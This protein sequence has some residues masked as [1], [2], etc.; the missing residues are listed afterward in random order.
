VSDLGQK[1]IASVR[2]LASERPGY[3]Y[4]R[5]NPIKNTAGSCVYVADGQPS[6]IVGHA[7]WELKLIGPEFEDHFQNSGG[8]EEIISALDLSIDAKEITWLSEAQEQQDCGVQWGHV[9]ENVDAGISAYLFLS[10]EKSLAE[11]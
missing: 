11:N 1:L 7:L 6:C 8:V 4:P 3:V 2:R 5:V 10:Q 9:P